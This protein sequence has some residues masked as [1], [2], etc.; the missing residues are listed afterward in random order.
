MNL[1]GIPDR[2]IW[3]APFFYGFVG[4]FWIHCVCRLEMVMLLYYNCDYYR[5]LQ[6]WVNDDGR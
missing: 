4:G 5:I 1:W 3:R 6:G 2:N